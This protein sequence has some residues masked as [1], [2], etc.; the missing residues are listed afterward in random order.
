MRRQAMEQVLPH[1]MDASEATR[2]A[3]LSRLSLRA[4]LVLL[5]I[6][7]IL[8]LLVFSLGDQYLDYR[9]ERANASE[10]AL[11]LA[12]GLSLVV[13]RDLEKRVA[14]L[15][16]LAHAP[17]LQAND[18]A[19]FRKL[20]EAVASEIF[21]GSAVVLL[22]AG[23]DARQLMNTG[24]PPDTP[25]PPT[26]SPATL[27]EVIRTGRPVVTDLFYSAAINRSTTGV[28]VPVAG[29]DGTIAYVLAMSVPPESFADV[30]RRQRPPDGWIVSVFD[31]SGAHLARTPS[32]GRSVGEKASDSLLPSLLSRKEGV[33]ESVSLEGI[34]LLTA[35]S[36]SEPFGWSV[37]V[38]MPLTLLTGPALASAI[39]VLTV[40]VAL[41]L[42]SL[43]LA[44]YVARRITGP[45]EVLA[46]A[47]RAP[48]ASP[49]I[50][51][52]ATGLPEADDV[53]RAL[54]T[55]RADRARSENEERAARAALRA[56]E[57]QLIQAQKMEAIGNLT[58]GMAHDFNNLLG[59]IIGNLDL[60]EPQLG[61]A[62]DA[63]ELLHEVRDAAQRG[64]DLTRRM[65]AFA[66]R[67]PLKPERIELNA[68]VGGVVRLLER[69]IGENIAISLNL[70][71]D[72]WPVVADPA[73][74]E[75]SLMNLATN[76]RDAM[77]NGGRLFI[78][79]GNRSLD[80]EYASRHADVAPGD[81]ALLEVSDTG[82][83]VPAEIMQ[84]I[85]DPFFTTKPVG[86]GT[87]LGLSM[88]YGFMKQS[89][90]HIN[91]YSEV[92]TGTTIRLY[93]PRASDGAQTAT[94]LEA[95]PLA[96][97]NGESVLVVED[98]ASLRRVVVRQLD[99]L[100]Y[101]VREAAT[102]A[103]AIHLLES[104]VKFDLL[105]T[106]IVIPGEMDGLALAGMVSARWPG[107]KVVLT[108]G[109]PGAKI[110]A[111]GIAAGTR[112]L[113]K[114]YRKADLARALHEVL[115]AAN[116]AA[117]AAPSDGTSAGDGG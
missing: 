49:S 57:G 23:P 102:A 113:S 116:P 87:G 89:G 31:R 12:R 56:A 38:G 47:A 13:E 66:R 15:E 86:Q 50:A 19:A 54:A 93:L 68:L 44:L 10:R 81:Y 79:T 75:A 103:A 92:G 106:D 62:G 25:L 98:N 51:D 11:E 43:L 61:P 28:E 104:G 63:Q 90:G 20:A 8:P 4:R 94:K 30:I 21:E 72:T 76:S 18:M 105:F 100:G 2:P 22:S 5:V 53:M 9:R 114:P 6:A 112:L 74:L 69:T 73:Q 3:I 77:P 101:D 32:A 84:Q 58:G 35:F 42:F 82:S 99:E 78:A 26:Q 39:Q 36:H 65:L 27:Q 71:P 16:T 64:A 108:S 67:Q 7:S 115:H 97:G 109:F 111:N 17:I 33:I 34:P 117:P 52:A 91:A 41:L 1:R 55:A 85:F 80:S 95:V 24:A 59:I 29:P 88:V 83:G 14:V 107:I 70:D 46:R 96:H 60:L 40:G 110:G 37:A 48:D 45:I